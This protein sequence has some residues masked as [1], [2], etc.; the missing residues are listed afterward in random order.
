MSDKPDPGVGWRLLEI[1]EVI[2]PSDQFFSC[3]GGWR[4][5]VSVSGERFHPD[6]QCPIRRSTTKDSTQGDRTSAE[7]ARLQSENADLRE[8]LDKARFEIV[9]LSIDKR[10][11]QDDLDAA[12]AALRDLGCAQGEIDDDIAQCIHDLATRWRTGMTEQRACEIVNQMRDDRR[13]EIRT[14][15]MPT[16]HVPTVIEGWQCRPAQPKPVTKPV[17]L[18]PD[19]WAE[20]EA[21]IKAAGGRV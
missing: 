10:S 19:K 8:Q 14:E 21:A 3:G 4:T 18:P 13:L 16:W 17:T 15:S 11:L 20:I 5:V 9:S 2:E 7:L 1:G 6:D 12:S